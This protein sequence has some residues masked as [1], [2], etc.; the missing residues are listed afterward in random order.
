MEQFFENRKLITFEELKTLVYQKFDISDPIDKSKTRINKIENIILAN[1]RID[2]KWYSDH[3][4][5]NNSTFAKIGFKESKFNNDDLRFNTFIDCYFKG[6]EFLN[7]DF[8]TCIFINCT[9][10]ESNF[11][12]CNFSYCDF[13]DCYIQY[14][15]IKECL[16]QFPNTRW[17]IC[18]NLSLEC[19]KAGNDVDYRKFFFDEKNASEKYY[20]YKF[21]HENN[22][23]YNKYNG[24]EQIV[25]LYQFIASKLNKW[26]WGYGE[27]LSRLLFNIILT[28]VLF[29]FGYYFLC[30]FDG[31]LIHALYI[32]FCNFLTISPDGLSSI[33]TIN[34]EP[35]TFSNFNLA[36]Y[37]YLSLLESIMGITFIGFFIAA[38]FRH[39]NRR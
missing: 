9:F 7:V 15:K 5:I 3:Y 8:N 22:G 36:R 19:L 30:G 38:L 29:G 1:E 21:W 31:N 24:T 14:E 26:I 13:R 18:K 28:I 35:Q 25:G 33:S 20:W 2:K 17:S 32:S 6:A 39:I 37:N 10:D 12:N 4:Y 11:M 27:K 23:Y 34:P 16:P